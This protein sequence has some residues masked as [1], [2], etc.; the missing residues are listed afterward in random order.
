MILLG[1]LVQPFIIA[2]IVLVIVYLNMLLHFLTLG[3]YYPDMFSSYMFYEHIS[4]NIPYLIVNG[5]V[6][7]LMVLL[8]LIK[9]EDRDEVY[10]WGLQV[11]GGLI[12]MFTIWQIC[13]V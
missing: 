6:L 11:L 4:P 2:E 5:I 8:L 12:L 10:F 13:I 1:F 3:L 7:I 9:Y